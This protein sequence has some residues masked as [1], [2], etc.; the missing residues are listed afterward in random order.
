MY[1]EAEIE[2][3]FPELAAATVEG[4][5]AAL[6]LPELLGLRQQR[7]RGAAE[8]SSFL[9]REAPGSAQPGASQETRA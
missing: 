1:T 2:N 7:E 6:L 4:V 3:Y 8:E 9:F 5:S